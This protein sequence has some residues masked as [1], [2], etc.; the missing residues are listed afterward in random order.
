MGLMAS[1]T[2]REKALWAVALC[3]L[4]MATGA[5]A[6][7]IIRFSGAFDDFA[8]TTRKVKNHEDWLGGTIDLTEIGW[9]RLDLVFVVSEVTVAEYL[10]GITIG[11]LLTN[12]SNIAYSSATF[13]VRVAGQTREFSVGY[14]APGKSV[15]FTVNVPDVPAKEA[16]SASMQFVRG[17]IALG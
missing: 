8:A 13:G 16:R 4:L 2:K 9:Q 10:S 6:H 14:V 15:I 7:A 17:M 3:A 5:L 12:T 11:G 1:L